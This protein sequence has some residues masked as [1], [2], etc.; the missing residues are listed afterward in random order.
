MEKA[1]QT[2][3]KAGVELPLKLTMKL[4][5]PAYA[6]RSGELIRLMLAMIDVEVEIIPVEWPIWLEQVFKQKDYDLTIISHTEPLDIGI[7]AR[8][9]YY[10]NFEHDGFKQIMQE[11]NLSNNEM[12]KKQ[13]YQEAQTLLAEQ[14]VNVFLFQLPKV[15][16]WRKGLHGMWANQPV[17]A[18]IVYDAHWE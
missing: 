18:N 10:F 12:V 1:K 13:L 17:Q 5:P 4:P 8:E 11:I 14:A 7:Y 16:I 3:T 2:L 15:A 9:G 6:R